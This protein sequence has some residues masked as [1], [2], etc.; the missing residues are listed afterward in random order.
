MKKS[1]QSIRTYRKS[2]FCS[3]CKGKCCKI[4]PGCIFPEDFIRNNK[5]IDRKTITD[6]VVNG[7]YA[8]DSW[9]G[10]GGKGVGLF[11]RPST[12]GKEKL[13]LDFSWG[14]ECVFLTKK[15]CKLSF[16]NR[17]LQCRNL[18]P[19]KNKRC[20]GDKRTGKYEAAVAWSK[21]YKLIESI[22]HSENNSKKD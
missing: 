12:K 5:K 17:P 13:I 9:E 14:G 19:R 2:S 11:I 7:T 22:V 16:K 6:M 10:F 18:K 20:T 8:F 21:Y 3:E 4:I 15:G 1:K